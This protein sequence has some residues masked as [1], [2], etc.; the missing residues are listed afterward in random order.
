MLAVVEAGSYAI[1][2]AEPARLAYTDV[3]VEA[4]GG[5]VDMIEA[6][7]AGPAGLQSAESTHEA[8]GSLADT[9][10]QHID[11]Q[12]EGR[13]PHAVMPVDDVEGL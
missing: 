12:S 6:L 1:D 3:A 13:V 11:A 5:Q 2:G 4:D 8:E 7:Y 10:W 9:I